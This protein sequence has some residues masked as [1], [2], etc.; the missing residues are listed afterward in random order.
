M[1]PSFVIWVLF[2]LVALLFVAP[3]A[4]RVH[5]ESAAERAAEEK[6]RAEEVRRAEEKHRKEREAAEQAAAEQAAREAARAEKARKAA[7]KR[8]EA[9]RK[10]DERAAAI[11]AREA[12]KARKAAE[13]LETARQLAELK[14]RELAAEREL[15][16]L[17][18]E[19]ETAEQAAAP[20]P[21]AE[22]VEKAAPA[23]E[24]VEAPAA[25][26]DAPRPFAGHVVAFTGRLPGMKRAEA[27]ALVERLGGRAYKDMPAG[28]TLLVVGDKPG[29]GKL[30]KADEWL[31][32]LR[33][34]TPAQFMEMV[35]AA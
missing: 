17:R 27:I 13:Q 21:H 8:A 5:R 24:P 25:R 18:R 34:I 35:N 12:E 2:A 23:A 6:R 3:A 26:Q 4:V 32:Q 33:K 31:G 11:Q 29:M 7:E 15:Q 16:A 30:D 9:K 14:E 28:T 19:R 10:A 22:P 20:A 1:Y